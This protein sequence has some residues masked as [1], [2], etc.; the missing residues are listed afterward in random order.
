MSLCAGVR[1]YIDKHGL[2]NCIFV[3][4]HADINGPLVPD[5]TFDTLTGS[6]PQHEAQQETWLRVT[7]SS[8]ESSS[9][10]KGSSSAC[11]GSSSGSGSGEES[12]E[13]KKL[14]VL[15][16]VVSMDVPQIELELR[17]CEPGAWIIFKKHHYL[18]AA[19][20]S[21]SSKLWYNSAS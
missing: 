3:S 21:G 15:T 12:G 9:I 8:S 6:L 14:E 19:L 16:E 2:T 1:E 7:R 10:G 4:C 13:E 11:S 20:A 5:F 17:N 18:N